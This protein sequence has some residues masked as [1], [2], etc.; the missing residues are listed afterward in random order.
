MDLVELMKKEILAQNITSLEDIKDYLYKRNGQI[1]TFDPRSVFCTAEERKSL[2]AERIDIRNVQKFSLNCFSWAY[3]FVDLLHSFGISAR[4]VIMGKENNKEHAGV[5][6][7]I[8]G[9][10]YYMDLM[11]RFED[12]IRIKFNFEPKYNIHVTNN[13]LENTLE[14][15]PKKAKSLEKFLEMAKK[16]LNN[17]GYIETENSN[18]RVFKFIE[19]FINSNVWGFNIDYIS[20]IQFINKLT[21][22]FLSSKN[23][24]HNTHFINNEENFYA[25]VYTLEKN[26]QNCYF[27]YQEVEPGRYELHEVEEKEILKLK[28]KCH[29]TQGYSLKLKKDKN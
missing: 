20:G 3:A 13:P 10:T 28:E 12:I 1:F 27:A 7:F 15:E 6:A 8:N 19:G 14:K 5:E 22:Y 9:E 29:F 16:E 21:S 11:A 23:R 4:V 17:L 24:P 2:N 26:S 18:Y 25:E